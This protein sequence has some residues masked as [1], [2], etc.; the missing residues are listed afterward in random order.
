MPTQ[1]TCGQC[2]KPMMI[3]EDMLGRRV[4]CP[5]CGNILIAEA[6]A[7]V[8]PAANLS[9][10]AGVEPGAAA[11]LSPPPFKLPPAPPPPPVPPPAS[12]LPD[13]GTVPSF[14]AP[15]G[16]APA[17]PAETSGL[18]IASLVCGIM[19]FMSCGFCL[20]P[21]VLAVIFGHMARS[22]IEASGGT[23]EG[24]GLAMAGL[25]LGY[26]SLVQVAL[27]VVFAALAG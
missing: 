14:G 21:Q 23:L 5:H 18:A 10:P 3:R 15:V 17:P 4:R 24:Q 27:L 11:P 9:A 19:A 6:A 7:T 2:S 1:I 13:R 20:L 16:Y 26:I 22:R 12:G 25:I 8:P